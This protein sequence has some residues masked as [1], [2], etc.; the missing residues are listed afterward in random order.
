[1]GQWWWR[2]TKKT[3]S[4]MTRGKQSRDSALIGPRSWLWVAGHV[5][6]PLI[7]IKDGTCTQAPALGFEETVRLSSNLNEEWE[8]CWQYP[9]EDVHQ[10]VEWNAPMISEIS[11]AI[12]TVYQLHHK[13][14]F[15]LVMHFQHY[16]N[17][18]STM[19][20]LSSQ[21]IRISS[22]KSDRFCL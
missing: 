4:L 3:P 11:L 13:H 19:W 1:M 5:T 10:W 14:G 9:Q 12:L 7:C 16:L 18:T 22:L 17:F 2:K 20:G 8:K 15:E 21:V 6:C